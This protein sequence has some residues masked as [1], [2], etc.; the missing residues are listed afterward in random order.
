MRPQRR[1]SVIIDRQDAIAFLSQPINVEAIRGLQ[2]LL[3]NVKDVSSILARVR[4]SIAL[5]PP[6]PHY[7]RTAKASA[8]DWSNIYKVVKGSKIGVTD[9]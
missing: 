2:S 5:F 9:L 6:S 8:G 3:K 4:Y 1:L 7:R